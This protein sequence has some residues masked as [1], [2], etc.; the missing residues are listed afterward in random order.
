MCGFDRAA[1][2]SLGGEKM[3]PLPLLFASLQNGR[4]SVSYS[5]VGRL[6]IL[7]CEGP[8]YRF[9]RAKLVAV[10]ARPI[11]ADVAR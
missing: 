10:L 1:G 6:A 5:V 11:G 3:S 7:A 8:S 4:K 2:W 9:I